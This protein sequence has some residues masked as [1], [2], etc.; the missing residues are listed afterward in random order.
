VSSLGGPLPLVSC[1][2]LTRDR[3]RLAERAIRCYQNQQYPHRELVIVCQGDRE[4][5]RQLRRHLDQTSIANARLIAADP[6][7]RLGALRNI[8]LDEARGD[9]VCVWDDDDC[10][11]P[12]RLARQVQHLLEADADAVFLSGS[13]HLFEADGVLHWLDMSVR[14]ERQLPLVPGTMVM[15]HDNRFRYPEAGQYA[16][17]GED[18]QLAVDLFRQAKVA[19][20]GDLGLLY[21]YTYHGNN[22]FSRLHHLRMRRY[23][24]PASSIRA[25]AGEIRDAL[26][27][28]PIALPV[29]VHGREGPVFT[30]DS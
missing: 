22:T 6:Q 1:L 2:M 11:H 23:S 21:L 4:Y 18:E 25:R 28:Y 15:R 17:W 9:L 30:V 3:P 24:L 16:H 29:A 26:A 14:P 8:S 12:D 10:S 13:L 27:Q 5:Q 20:I 19:M 7:L